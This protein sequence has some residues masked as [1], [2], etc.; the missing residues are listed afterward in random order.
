MS[1]NVLE[2]VKSIDEVEDIKT[3]P[4]DI[5]DYSQVDD[6]PISMDEEFKKIF[7][8][9]VSSGSIYE[10]NTS[11]SMDLAITGLLQTKIPNHFGKFVYY[12]K[13]KEENLYKVALLDFND[14][15]Y[16]VVAKQ[17]T[18]VKIEDLRKVIPPIV[19]KK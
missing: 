9:I 16:F 13:D 18:E 11:K 6:S 4:G 15:D 3:N 12:L 19:S 7:S 17:D 5:A 14:D 1:K 8:Q 10:F 2:N